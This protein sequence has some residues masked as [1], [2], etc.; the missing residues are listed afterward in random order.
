LGILDALEGLSFPETNLLVA[1]IYLILG[2]LQAKVP[3]VFW[4]PQKMF[5][6]SLGYGL[7]REELVREEAN[8][9]VKSAPVKRLLAEH[10]GLSPAAQEDYLLRFFKAS[11]ERVRKS[12]FPPEP[13]IVG[14]PT[15]MEWLEGEEDLL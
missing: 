2:A 1:R 12:P 10:F 15:S 11:L 14:D 13:W 9:L 4:K 6:F 5:R 8:P 3:D 7:R